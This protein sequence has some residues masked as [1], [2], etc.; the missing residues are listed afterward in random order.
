MRASKILRQ[1]KELVDTK[2]INI[3]DAI[4]Y[5]DRERSGLPFT[6]YQK[7][8]ATIILQK[9]DWDIDRAIILAEE[10]EIMDKYF[11]DGLVAMT[12]SDW[13]REQELRREAIQK[14]FGR[15]Q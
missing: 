10:K 2:N 6:K 11:P 12:F 7:R 4:F 8:E 15:G 13:M 3:Y 1:A 9:A 5:V 14:V